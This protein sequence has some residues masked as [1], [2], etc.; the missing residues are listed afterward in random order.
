M[1]S[2]SNS[3]GTRLR[4]KFRSR[5]CSRSIA[6]EIRWSCSAVSTAPGR[7]RPSINSIYPCRRM[8]RLNIV[9]NWTLL[10]L[11]TLLAPAFA[12][13]VITTI[14][15]TDWLFPGDGRQATKAPIGGV[16]YLGV[17]VDRHGAFYIADAD[18][19]MV[20]KVTPD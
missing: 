6:S 8:S 20:F 3:P 13:N 16:F 4:M 19:E 10:G 5:R 2:A 14:A 17:A 15:G 12:Q 7:S 1:S 18:N 9:S 11:C